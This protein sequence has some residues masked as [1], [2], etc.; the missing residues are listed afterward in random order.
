MYYSLR[1][2]CEVFNETGFT[3]VNM[4]FN[5]INGGSIGLTLAKD[6][7][8]H[9]DV[10]RVIDDE[11]KF[12]FDGFVERVKAHPAALRKALEPFK[13]VVGFGASTKGNVLLQHCDLGPN[14]VLAI[15]DVNEDKHGC[16]TA[17]GIPIDSDDAV[18]ELEPDCYL[19][20]PWHFREDILRRYKGSGRTF[21]FP[22]PTPEVVR[23]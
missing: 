13:R 17:T 7:E 9:P 4:V 19:V 1:N 3:V 5:E 11:D 16:V 22:L 20:L 14:D 15:A 6:G 12:D 21:L 10:Q 2:L 18:D 23:A 8:E